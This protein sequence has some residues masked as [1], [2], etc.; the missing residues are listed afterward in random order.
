[1]D[2]SAALRSPGSTLKPFLYA[3]G[4]DRGL[5]SPAEV[6]QDAPE[7]AAGISNAD[8]A[9]LGALLPRQALANSRNVPAAGLLNRMGVAEGMAVLRRAGLTEE[10][11]TGARYGLGLAIGAMPT[12][13]DWL[14]QAYRALSQDGVATGLRWFQGEPPGPSVP[15]AS[16]RSARL[17]AA[18][19]SD[20][21]ARLP[22]FPRYGPSEYPFAV[23]LKTGTS[24]G[25]RD[26][27]TVAWSADYVVGAWMGRPDAGP[28]A[29]LSG[30]RAAARLVQAALLQL[31]GTGRT[32]LRAGAFAAPVG[33][34]VSEVCTETGRPGACAQRLLEFTN[35]GGDVVEA[36]SMEAASMGAGAVEAA[37]VAGRALAIVEPGPDAHV[38]RNPDAPPGLQKLALR[39][40][41]S[42]GVRQVVW[43][44][45]GAP[46]WVGPADQ[47]YRW[48]MTPGVHR[49]QLRLPLEDVRSRQVRVVV[50]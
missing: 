37:A 10:G 19:L 20:P 30:A 45:D 46:A 21:M 38:W 8:D 35:A 13:L 17:V 40:Q 49:F 26:S 6:M 50:E 7:V 5:L 4:L 16:R 28:T 24:Q 36:A 14:V 41:V 31:H 39:A 2:F 3:A 12:R 34:A 23:A 47:P 11:G 48:P 29:G 15:V 42:P 43:L 25:Y 1:M 9:F 18:F 32:D 44:V 22:A 33:Q 27:W